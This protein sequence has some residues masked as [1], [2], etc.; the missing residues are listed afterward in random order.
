MKASPFAS[1]RRLSVTVFVCFMVLG[2][3]SLAVEAKHSQF[4]PP[5]SSTSYLS[6]AVKMK[7]CRAE[8][9][10]IPPCLA[11]ELDPQ[12]RIEPESRLFVVSTIRTLSCSPR[13]RPQLRAPPATV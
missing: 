7:E 12:I 2:V 3:I 13:V 11:A 10:Q 6:Q 9:G 8:T 1:F 4:N 5:D